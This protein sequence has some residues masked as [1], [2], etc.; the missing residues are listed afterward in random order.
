M[1]L[2]KLW[3]PSFTGAP[4]SYV[5]ASSSAGSG[6]TAG[7]SLSNPVAL[8]AAPGGGLRRLADLDVSVAALRNRVSMVSGRASACAA[9]ASAGAG[10]AG[11]LGP[12]L[13][14]VIPGLLPLGRLAGH[15]KDSRGA[16]QPDSVSGSDTGRRSLIGF[17]G[18]PEDD[19]DSDD[20]DDSD[21]ESESGSG[22]GS[23]GLEDGLGA[24]SSAPLAHHGARSF[25]SSSSSQSGSHGGASR[26]LGGEL[27]SVSS[28][29]ASISETL[30]LR[31][32]ASGGVSR[33]V[34]WSTAV[35]AGA[36]A[37]DKD[38]GAD[39]KQP[40]W[41]HT[42]ALSGQ[43]AS[44][45]ES[46]STSAVTA[47]TA[48]TDKPASD[49]V[50]S[51]S[52]HRL[53]DAASASSTITASVGSAYS[54]AGSLSHDSR[55]LRV[56]GDVDRYHDLDAAAARESM[57]SAASAGAGGRHHDT[58]VRL[59]RS[60][61]VASEFPASASTTSDER[62]LLEE[63]GMLTGSGVQS[64]T[65]MALLG[66]TGTSG[67]H[68]SAD[69]SFTGPSH[70]VKGNI[71]TGTLPAPLTHWPLMS[72]AS[73]GMTRSTAP[74]PASGLPGWGA[75]ARGSSAVDPSDSADSA[76]GPS[77][78]P[79]AATGHSMIHG[80]GVDLHGRD[81]HDAGP[82]P[83]ISG[84]LSLELEAQRARTASSP[85]LLPLQVPA[86]LGAPMPTG[87]ISVSQAAAASGQQRA[88]SAGGALTGGSLASDVT[89]LGIAG[90]T[91]SG[92]IDD[93]A[94]GPSLG[95]SLSFSL[96]GYHAASTAG[97]SRP[98][99][100]AQAPSQAV[101]QASTFGDSRVS[102]VF[103]GFP[104]GPYHHDGAAT[105]G[106]LPGLFP[107]HSTTGGMLMPP[108]FQVVPG[109]GPASASG[110]QSSAPGYPTTQSHDDAG[111][112]VKRKLP[113]SEL[114]V[115]RAS[116]PEATASLSHGA[117]D[118]HGAAKRPRHGTPATAD[119]EPY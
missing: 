13:P 26:G 19:S 32:P 115:G 55:S 68:L 53:G 57:H 113:A 48:A 18:Q 64:V 2:Y 75:S 74:L 49:S 83:A 65:V 28:Q 17:D 56:R 114:E 47:S 31:L 84:T 86:I 52:A 41:N 50:S 79:Q 67:N 22:D 91:G 110:L 112:A 45:S 8:D 21:S 3:A 63:I 96:G 39:A 118:A 88:G 40:L 108:P 78:H 107:S 9:V 66:S 69:N 117:S 30:S 44:V 70:D 10:S 37:D 111:G 101:P 119:S 90:L 38:R 25:R 97:G 81:H 98:A 71:M 103:P 36:A 82:G 43:P 93:S 34:R 92:N 94:A 102:S 105:A 99:G 85:A 100:P 12:F 89:A 33:T 5:P 29:A 6:A 76:S 7:G 106:P 72:A 58:A 80:H 42:A 61:Q 24:G 1:E 54:V 20:S 23:D 77:I 14:S 62:R 87:M 116:Q 35:A 51:G 60:S 104:T 15:R 73:L 16:L 109:L 27:A 46:E 59:G 4:L 95:P 11:G